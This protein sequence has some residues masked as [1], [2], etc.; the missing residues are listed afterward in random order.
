MDKHTFSSEVGSKKHLV[1]RS[2]FH[3]SF[4]P[5][6]T[7]NTAFILFLLFFSTLSHAEWV[8]WITDID[9]GIQYNDNINRSAFS[10]DVEDDT[11]LKANISLGRVNQV[12]STFRYSLSTDFSAE[13]FDQF[14]LLNSTTAG[15]TFSARKKLGLGLTVPW[16][17]GSINMSHLN[18]RDSVRSSQN[19]G[20]D[21]QAG[22]RYSE[23]LDIVAGYRFHTRNGKS[24]PSAAPGLDGNVFDQD[25]QE[26]FLSSSYLVTENWLS[27]FG[28]SY[29]DGEVDSACTGGN[30]ATVLM[31]D[32][33]A[34]IKDSIFGG[35][36][37]RLDVEAYSLSFDNSYALGRHA[38]INVGYQLQKG[39]GDAG[40][41]KYK[42]SIF[43]VIYKYSY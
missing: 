32:I 27:S 6:K 22:K 26:I 40:F 4:W 1:Y 23:R 36:V 11:S 37:Y 16:V 24:K 33:S 35:C 2:C 20:I 21:I 31:W 14:E 10:S 41:L 42:N 7:S 34:I 5:K 8:E 13:Y 39:K 38:S 28:V 18:V 19:I 3:I 43:S 25:S 30:V 12:T 15:A 9:S 17:K 29:F